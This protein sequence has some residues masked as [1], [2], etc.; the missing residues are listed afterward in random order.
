MKLVRNESLQGHTIYF[1][2]PRGNKG[3][4]IKPGERLVVPETYISKHVI[5]LQ[6]RKLFSVKEA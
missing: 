4:Y 1:K 5:S 6:E 3:Y 2:T